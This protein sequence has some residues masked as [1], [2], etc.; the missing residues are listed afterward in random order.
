MRILMKEICC[1]LGGPPKQIE[2]LRGDFELSR[3]KVAQTG[4]SR[5]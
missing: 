1:N 4:P 5:C 3:P 2:E